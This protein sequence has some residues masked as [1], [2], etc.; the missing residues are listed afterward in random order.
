MGWCESGAGREV[1][2]E[3]GLKTFGEDAV[4]GLEFEGLVDGGVSG[5][6]KGRGW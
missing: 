6:W 5:W 4:V 2:E 3:G 1:F